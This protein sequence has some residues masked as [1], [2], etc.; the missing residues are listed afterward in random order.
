MSVTDKAEIEATLQAAPPVQ[1]EERV[2]A[3][4]QQI[5]H[6]NV[7]YYIHD[8]PTRTDAEYDAL[9][10]ELRVL[11]AE[12]PALV[13]PDSPTQRVG[14][15]PS[16]EFGTVTH[17]APMLSLGNVF[18]QEDLCAWSERVYRV[19]G[20]DTITFDV[21]PKIDGL[22]VALTYTD[23]QFVRGATRGDGFTGEDVTA[24]LRTVRT[25]PLRLREAA[26]G[27]IEVRGEVY[28][29]RSGFH[30]LNEERERDGLATFAN[31][32]NAAAGSLRQ[33]D[34]TITATRPLGFFAYAAGYWTDPAAMPVRAQSAL[35]HRL[36]DLGFRPS[37]H[38]VTCDTTDAVW[39]RCQHWHEQRDALD[40]EIDGVVIK[41]DSLGV[42]EELGNVAREPR[43]ATAYKFPATQVVTRVNAITIQVGR[44]GS[45]NPVAELDP[46]NV[47]G[48]LV[49]RATLHNEDEIRRKDIRIGDTV[50][51][52]RAGDV[53][54]QVVRVVTERRTGEEREFHMPEHCPACGAL[55]ERLPDEAM[56]Y[57]TNISCP[58]QVRERIKHYV[59]R[60]AMDIE[61]LGERI[62]DRF[63]D[64]SFL[65]DV[66]D[67]YHL[68]PAKLLELEKFGEKSVENLLRS[69][70]G[71]K[72]RPL[73][74][75][76]FGL[77]I[78]HVGERSAGLLADAFSA[79]DALIAASVEDLG[80]VNGV[81]DIV[82]QSIVDFFAEPRNR[83][84]IA[85]LAAS[86][87]RM[88]DAPRAA[89]TGPQPLA[90]HTY[91]LTG[92]LESMSR[93]QAEEQLKALGAQTTSTV[94]KKT[95]GVI[96][97][98]EPGS[99]AE[100]AATLKVPILDE[101]GLL[102]LLA[103]NEQ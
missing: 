96:V 48:V 53:I 100:R 30:R 38:A 74:R 29:T 63:V 2:A 90:G 72:D 35:L 13:T 14:A 5:D 43:W 33:L 25:I 102:A 55:V 9:M 88:A 46:V 24:N 45:L 89:P 18:S 94:T 82:A 65:S 81:G 22:A 85:K 27:T 79:M 17:P 93:P 49:A 1:I 95:T 20:R 76:V 99:K 11:E 31:P 62:V 32:R 83:D 57:C 92:R 44:T 39:E 86:G 19:A 47:A 16:A 40:F 73:A 103:S 87:V 75:L 34:P 84:L 98:A 50:I 69:I 8:N 60:G 21:E 71:S 15:A 28:L 52:Q 66:A 64:L 3:L 77:G 58:A 41:V 4:R 23:G 61:G 80:K 12:Y 68:D 97:G 101:A 56:A 78:R 51:I 67:I 42:Q 7:E 10:N 37:P 70:A 59:S 26:P 6:A 54:P 36:H 91:V